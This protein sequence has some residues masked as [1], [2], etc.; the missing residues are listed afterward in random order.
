[1]ILCVSISYAVSS[2]TSRSVSYSERNSDMHTHTNVV[3]SCV[4]VDHRGPVSSRVRKGSRHCTYGIFKLG[5]HLGNY[6]TH[7]FEL[8]EHVL[9]RVRLTTHDRRHLHGTILMWTEHRL[10]ARKL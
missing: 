6:R 3:F 2:C 7:G 4:P 5:V 1:M 10:Q 8:R 9:G